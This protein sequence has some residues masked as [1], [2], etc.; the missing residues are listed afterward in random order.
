[1]SSKASE[2]LPTGETERVIKEAMR[3]H[4][5]SGEGEGMSRDNLLHWINRRL[6]TA[7]KELRRTRSRGYSVEERGPQGWDGYIEAL[8]AV[9]NRIKRAQAGKEKHGN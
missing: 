2:R 7:R 9:R 3:K 1:M 8:I 5:T 4:K 6:L